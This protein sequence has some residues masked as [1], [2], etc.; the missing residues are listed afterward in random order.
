LTPTGAGARRAGARH[1]RE[2][3]R[4]GRDPHAFGE[5]A[6]LLVMLAV[7]AGVAVA[8]AYELHGNGEPAA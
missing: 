5:Q 3:A 8:E 7:L 2:H 6:L 1:A 4:G